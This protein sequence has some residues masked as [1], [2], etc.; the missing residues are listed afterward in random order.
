MCCRTQKSH[1]I[2]QKLGDEILK[3][4]FFLLIL[5]FF[6]GHFWNQKCYIISISGT[7]SDCMYCQIQNIFRICQLNSNH[8]KK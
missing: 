3:G 8:S 4:K 7:K 2:K 6:Y 1:Q 5:F